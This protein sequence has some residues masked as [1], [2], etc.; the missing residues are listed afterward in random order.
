M[1]NNY[2][3]IGS[4]AQ[5]QEEHA[6][7]EAARR[8]IEVPAARNIRIDKQSNVIYLGYAPLGAG[9]SEPLWLIRAIETT[10]TER[11]FKWANGS[12]TN[13]QVWDDR[14]SLSYTN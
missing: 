12:Y 11:V 4:S 2:H 8:T 9:S 5:E 1:A 6:H 10:G 14:A 13:N 3:P 7:S